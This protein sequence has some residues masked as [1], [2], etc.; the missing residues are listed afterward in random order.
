VPHNLRSNLETGGEEVLLRHAKAWNELCDRAGLAPFHRP[1]WIISYLRAFEE[2]PEISLLTITSGEDLLAVLPLIATRGWYSGIPVRKLAGPANAHSVR[3]DLVVAPD[4]SIDAAASLMWE[5]L[6]QAGGWHMLELPVFPQHG[7]CEKI[8]ALAEADGHK[9]LTFLFQDSPILRMRREDTGKLNPMGATSRHF[10]HELRRFARLLTEETGNTP[11]L[12]CHK[13][14]D[15]DSLERFY[16][17]EAAG[18]K[19]ENGSAIACDVQTRQFYDTIA[20]EGSR[21]GYFCLH[22]LETDGRLAAAAFSVKTEHC[23]SP[24][25]IAYDESLHRGGPGQLLFQSMLQEC[26]E[27]QIPEFFF[28]G[29]KDRYKTCWTEETLP[30]FN[31]YIFRPGSRARLAYE[32]RIKV[33]SPLGRLRRQIKARLEERNRK[34]NNDK[35][36][37]AA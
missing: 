29:S 37:R 13:D 10:R 16:R 35:Q 12:V 2:K 9:T 15:P 32:C 26:A 36:K 14:P 8:I 33:L 17:L 18:W 30:H 21:R 11:R 20:Q 25:K 19:G 4:V 24:M 1:E 23:F 7:G 3:F 28:G 22:T 6:K 31:G 34:I 5:Q 27:S